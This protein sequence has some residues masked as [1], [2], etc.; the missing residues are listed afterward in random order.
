MKEITIN[1]TDEAVALLEKMVAAEG[2]TVEKKVGTIVNNF[3]VT[4]G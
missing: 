1:L 3:F 2:T 4:G